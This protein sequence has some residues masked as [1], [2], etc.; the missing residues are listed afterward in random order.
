MA[1]LA[2][3]DALVQ[4]AS[5]AV[6]H[7]SPASVP[8]YAAYLAREVF[9]ARRAVVMLWLDGEAPTV[10]GY[11]GDELA[12]PNPLIG[13]C[14]DAI[15]TGVVQTGTGAFALPLRQGEA[16]VGALALQG[17]ALDEVSQLD[18]RRLAD[19]VAVTVL[20]ERALQDA[21]ALA[22]QLQHA[23]ETRVAVEQAKGLVAGALGTTVDEAL[24]RIRGYARRNQRR[25]AE[26]AAAIVARE[27][28]V[29]D[30]DPEPVPGAPVVLLGPTAVAERLGVP[31]AEVVRLARVG[32]LQ[33]EGQG[34]TLLIPERAVAA[35]ERSDA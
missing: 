33:H 10:A 32:A 5:L 21:N 17:D 22:D 23:L 14:V 1:P 31:V 11:A 12:S 29:D 13:L 28:T 16:V 20:R 6:S 18:A 26:V 4:L 25:L 3:A 34:G 35:Y 8:S 9:A 15:E 19:V 7:R 30:L 24:A 27:L 2:L